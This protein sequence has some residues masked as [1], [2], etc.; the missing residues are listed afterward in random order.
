VLQPSTP[1]KWY[2]GWI[3][4]HFTSIKEKKNAVHRDGWS[5]VSGGY[6]GIRMAIQVNEAVGNSE[7][8]GRPGLKKQVSTQR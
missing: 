6:L 5:P 3:E 4:R 7:F 1:S 2:L 8:L